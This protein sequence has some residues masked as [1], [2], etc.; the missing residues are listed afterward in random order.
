MEDV[1]I[2]YHDKT[3][4]DDS[5][6]FWQ[7]YIDGEEPKTD[8]D[9]DLIKFNYRTKDYYTSTY[10]NAEDYA[11]DCSGFTFYAA[12]LPNG[13]WLEPGA[14]GWWGMSSATDEDRKQWRK[15]QKEILKNAKEENWYITLVDCHI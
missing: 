10:K 13:E 8:K 3:I 5:I 4:Y 1:D 2:G 6:R 11:D 15:T 12:I 9:N 7:L 14:M